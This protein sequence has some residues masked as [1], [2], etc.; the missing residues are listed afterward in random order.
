MCR[1]NAK[2]KKQYL[3]KKNASFFQAGRHFF[4]INNCCNDYSL[5]SA[6][7]YLEKLS[8][9]VYERLTEEKIACL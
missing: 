5:P 3:V 6:N 2:G 4:H 7:S 8:N 1:M 9:D